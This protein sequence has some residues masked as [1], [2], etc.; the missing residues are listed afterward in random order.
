MKL[1]TVHFKKIKSDKDSTVMEHKDGHQL[2]IAHSRLSPKIRAQLAAI[3]MAEGGNP[4]L[5]ESK[6]EP[7]NNS[8]YAMP[9]IAHGYAEGG[10]VLKENYSEKTPLEKQIKQ[11][12][13]HYA[14]GG[15]VAYE[16]GLPCQ[17]PNCKSHGRPHPNCRC[18]MGMA[19]GGKAEHYCSKPRK[20]GSECPYYAEG[21]QASTFA[22]DSSDLLNEI[23]PAQSDSYNSISKKD[24][25]KQ[26]L[27]DLELS[28]KGGPDFRSMQ[29]IKE[30]KR[31][32]DQEPASARS[33]AQ[34]KSDNALEVE[35]IEE[36]SEDVQ[37]QQAN[38]PVTPN[39][40]AGPE[41]ASEP[42]PEAGPQPPTANAQPPATGAQSVAAQAQSLNN[43][44]DQSNT[45]TQNDLT[46]GHIQP[47]TMSS[48]FAKNDT[49]GKI[50]TI[51]GLMLSGA[52]SGISGQRNALLD[53]MQKQ[54]D[55]DLEAQKAS[56][57][58]AQNFYRMHQ[59]ANL[60]NA[61]AGR[62]RA[63]KALIDYQLASN[64]S[65]NAAFAIKAKDILNMPDNTPELAA[66]KASMLQSLGVY[67]QQAQAMI[68]DRN[69]KTAAL[70]AYLGTIGGV[71]QIAGQKSE[72]Q[73]GEQASSDQLFAPGYKQKLYAAQFN[74]IFSKE[75]PKILEEAAAA[76]QAQKG[77]TEVNRLM[78]LLRQ[79]ATI[80]GR[81][82]RMGAGVLGTM[83]AGVGAA[84]GGVKGAEV[85]GAL[86]AGASKLGSVG[87]EANKLYEANQERLLKTVIAA[88]PKGLPGHISEDAVKKLT[89]EQGDS[90]ET[91]NT[92]LEG[93]RQLIKNNTVHTRL[94]QIPG[95][96]GK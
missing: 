82:A 35:P 83:G 95:V 45:A 72:E 64:D 93:L 7:H 70:G 50:G 36:G 43:F 24:N 17:N 26:L 61:Q 91:Y 52:G 34:D 77:L 84:I 79:Q 1:N 11:E 8:K 59:Q 12:V 74:P 38:P 90:A 66:K 49:A 81:L 92:K 31:Y 9:G 5:E 88:F 6:K 71:D 39:P 20:H 63:D 67:G 51:F 16:N 58:N 46:M 44:L 53:L 25:A 23:A 96:W 87:N 85:G 60:T 76:E 62:T 29:G 32:S 22:D 94:D 15:D 27:D 30:L 4:K 57:A 19:E 13:P 78:P 10:A 41:D 65:L 2:T 80:R 37:P 47:E 18:Y 68:K 48:L 56:A 75:Y 86:G 69:A 28:A 40:P 54:I 89:P 55:N 73:K 33:P 42:P 21:G 14:S 3:P